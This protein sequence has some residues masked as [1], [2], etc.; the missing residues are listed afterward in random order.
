MTTQ[1]TERDAL[2]KLAEAATPGPW[3]AGDDQDSDYFL[4]GPPSFDAVVTNLVVKLHAQNN[5]L[6]LAEANPA[7]VIELLDAMDAQALRIGELEKNAEADAFL[8]ALANDNAARL[9]VERDALRAELDALRGQEPVGY[10]EVEIPE[11]LT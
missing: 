6:F 11:E 1:Q 10:V 5:A 8:I 7:K 4:I 9:L 2:R 3:I